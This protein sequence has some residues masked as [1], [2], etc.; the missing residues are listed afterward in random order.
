M[1]I[2]LME[3]AEGLSSLFIKT[4]I[5]GEVHIVSLIK[6]APR[7]SLPLFCIDTSRFWS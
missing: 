1:T 3:L 2:S 5:L 7:S 6:A 4:L